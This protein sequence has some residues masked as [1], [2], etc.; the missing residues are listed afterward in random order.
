MRAFTEARTHETPDEL[1]ITEH[2]FGSLAKPGLRGRARPQPDNVHGI[3]LI[4]TDRGGDVTRIAGTTGGL[5]CWILRGWASASAHRWSALVGRPSS[6]LAVCLARAPARRPAVSTWPARRSPPRLPRLR[7]GR[8]ITACRSI[9][10]G[11]GARFPIS[12][13]CGYPGLPVD[14]PQPFSID[15]PMWMRG[16]RMAGPASDWS[17]WVYCARSEIPLRS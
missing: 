7:R 16:C 8:L 10:S 3:P 15:R 1:F 12:T 13:L 9:R 2:P 11:S 14:F 17:S 4:Q 6:P 5:H